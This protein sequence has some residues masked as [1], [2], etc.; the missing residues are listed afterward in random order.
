MAEN[1]IT[2]ILITRAITITKRI[3]IINK[4]CMEL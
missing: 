3:V 1:V 2:L 4:Q